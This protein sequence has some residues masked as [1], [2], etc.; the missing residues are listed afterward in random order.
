MPNGYAQAPL[1]FTK[2]LKQPFDFLRKHGYSSVVYIDYSYLQGDTYPIVWRT[3]MLLRNCLPLG[4]A[5]NHEKSVFHPA[6]RLIFLGFVLDSIT[7]TISL[8]E[9]RKHIL[10]DMCKNLLSDGPHTIRTVASAVHYCSSPG[11][12]IWWFILPTPRAV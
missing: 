10:L 4:F 2:L 12:K 1:I 6:Q 7:M 8:T 11:S 3:F 9:K 5:I